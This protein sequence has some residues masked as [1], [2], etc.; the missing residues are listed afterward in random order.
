[1]IISLILIFIMSA[2]FGCNPVKGEICEIWV[3][4]E[5]GWITKEDVMNILYL[6]YGKVEING[7]EVEFTPTAEYNELSDR[8]QLDIKKAWF[9]YNAVGDK[10]V[11]NEHIKDAKNMSFPLFMPY[12]YYHGCYAVQDVFPYYYAAWEHIVETDGFAFTSSPP[13]MIFRYK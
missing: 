3:A 4:Y 11:D 5:Q 6:R 10:K 2:F 7:E 9:S 1:M 12:G 13:I 8:Q